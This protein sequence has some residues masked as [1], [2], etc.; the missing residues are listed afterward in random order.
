[1]QSS[2][3]IYTTQDAIEFTAQVYDDNYQPIDDAQIEVRVQSGSETSTISLNAFGGGQFQGGYEALREGEYKF[4]ANVTANGAAI[5]SDQ[6]TFSVGGFDAEFLDTRMNKPLLQQ[7][8][9]QTGG[10]YYDCNNINLLA[11]DIGMMPNF[12]PRDTSNSAEIE[13]WNS[14][15]M[16][17][18]V[19]LIFALEWFLRKRNGML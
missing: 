19:I 7:I 8:A 18:F 13:I 17:T 14:R 2:K 3:H 16:L 11:H 4:T 5:G 12:K 6:G 15:W 10:R 9:A 1:V